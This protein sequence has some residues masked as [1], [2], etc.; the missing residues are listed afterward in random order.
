MTHGIIKPW[1]YQEVLNKDLAASARTQKI[2]HGWISDDIM[3]QS[4]WQTETSNYHLVS[5]HFAKTVDL[6]YSYFQ[7]KYIQT[8]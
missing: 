8:K 5:K 4:I 7:V 6:I 2:G 3:N 1:K